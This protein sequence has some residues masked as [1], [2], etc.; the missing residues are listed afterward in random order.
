MQQEIFRTIDADGAI[1]V[2]TTPL[3]NEG[4]RGFYIDKEGIRHIGFST[5][6][7]L[8]AAFNIPDDYDLTSFKPNSWVQQDADGPF[9]AHQVKAIFTPPSPGKQ[10][11]ED[12]L[13]QIQRKSPKATFKHKEVLNS[14]HK[15]MLEI[16]VMDPHIGMQCYAPGSDHAYDVD[17]ASQLYMWAVSE[18]SH[19]GMN[20]GN[21]SEI[22]FPIGNDFLHAEPMALAKGIG[23]A[24]A[25]GT[26]Q[27]EMIAWH[28]AYI[29]G[30][31]LLREAITFLSE[32]APV[33][34]IVIPGNHDRYSAFTLGRV[35]NA[36]FYNNENVRVD[37][38]AS[39]YKFKRYGVNL[40]GFE[41]GH[42][43]A[44]IRL[45]A[46]MANECPQDWSETSYREWHLGD[47]HR[48][49]SSK[50]A[51]L[52]EQGV[53]VEYLPSLVAPNEWHRIKSF[54]WQK[55]GA[56]AWVWDYH[57]GPTARL[58]VNLNSYT[59]KPYQAP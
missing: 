27:P 58:Q 25:G 11:L 35:M 7:D 37:C 2:S 38:D 32:L 24:T 49:G 17:F 57:Y 46:L 45:A 16:S 12:L 41:H 10:V 44:P 43:V 21:I 29:E 19:L 20:Y 52:E 56:M 31:R 34:V 54:N 59:G 51:T 55:R 14:K 1:H 4:V 6:Q 28:Q 8:R 48:K 40:I 18:L 42:S 3:L 53:S 15:R 22:L 50:P 5:E 13:S 23:H 30:E 26:V 33:H 9:I 47:Q 39:P 36:Y